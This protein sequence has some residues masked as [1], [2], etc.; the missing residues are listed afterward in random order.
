MGFLVTEK[1]ALT[2][3]L[4]VLTALFPLLN[5]LTSLLVVKARAKSQ[6]RPAAGGLGEGDRTG[7]SGEEGRSEDR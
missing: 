6:V 7:E 5:S 2:I 1:K 4:S 3:N